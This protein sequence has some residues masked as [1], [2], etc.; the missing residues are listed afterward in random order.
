MG[1]FLGQN[2][3]YDGFDK[4]QQEGFCHATFSE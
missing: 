3:F 1:V 4:N 2:N